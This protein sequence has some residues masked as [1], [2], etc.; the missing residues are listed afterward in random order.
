MINILFTFSEAASEKSQTDLRSRLMSK[1]GIEAVGRISPDAKRPF[2]R[3]MWYAQ[4]SD[5]KTAEVLTQELN[6]LSEI[7]SAEV[8]PERGLYTAR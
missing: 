7:E 2:L 5:N 4:V 1:Q 6:G 3:R 8:P